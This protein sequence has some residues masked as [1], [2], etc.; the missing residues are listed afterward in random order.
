SPESVKATRD[1]TADVQVIGFYRPDEKQDRNDATALLHL[2]QEQS[3]HVK[4]TML[5]ADQNAAEEQ[6][7]GVTIPGSLAL[8]YRNR[9]P[10]VLTLA[11][12]TESDVTGA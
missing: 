6:E 12:Q 4:V 1:L 8:Q 2:Y 5:D 9:P 10:V 7:L 11:S 3:P